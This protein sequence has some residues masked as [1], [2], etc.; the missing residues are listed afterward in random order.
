MKKKNQFQGNVLTASYGA[1]VSWAGPNFLILESDD[2]PLQSGKLSTVEASIVVSIPCFGAIISTLFYT[3]MLDR[4]SRKLL[5][6]SLAVPQ[7]VNLLY[8]FI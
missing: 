2:T 5:L 7:L 4:L 1:S 3:F 6:L 8:K